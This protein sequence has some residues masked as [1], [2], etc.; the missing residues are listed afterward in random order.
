M[1]REDWQN[2]PLGQETRYE[3]TYNPQ[4]LHPIP[5]SVSRA[6]LGIDGAALPFTGADE[7]W[8]FE[9][10]WLN[11]RGVPQ[12]AVARFRF[13]ASSPSMIESKSFKLYLNSFNQTE[14]DSAE[15]V[16]A[17][18]EKDLSA[19][20]GSDVAV[21]LFDVEDPV[22]AV[23]A[24]AGTCV[25][26]L[27]LET[28]VYQPDAGLL[29]L[30]PGA[31]T[32]ETLYS[33]LLR[34]NCPVTGQPDWA[35]VSITY[36]GPQLDHASVLAY[37]VS[38]REHQDFHEHCV[39]RIYCDLQQLADFAQLTV[40]ARYTRRGGLDINPLRTSTGEIVFPGRFARQ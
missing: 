2:L 23:Q 38:F 9:L 3:S 1:Q 30:A 32:E 17:T 29:K 22:L 6:Q 35:T 36:R 39:E 27:D 26:K 7:W 33:H 18:L 12:V 19:A 10:S 28:R 5:R 34:S 20:A 14:F 21:T 31:A 25:D 40:C 24:P 8:G 16:R 11:H 4:L 37:V 13:A 15:A